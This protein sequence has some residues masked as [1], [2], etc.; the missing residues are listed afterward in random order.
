MNYERI[1]NELCYR[2]QNRKWSKF[3]YEKH[4]II[5]KSMGGS[6]YKQNIAILTPREHAVAHLLL[7]KFLT[8]KDKAK[9]I[10]ALKTMM[11]FRNKNRNQLTTREYDYLRKAYQIQCQT[12]EYSSWRSELTK[13][14]WTPERRHSVSEKTRQQWETGNKREI[15]GSDEYRSKKSEQTKDRWKNPEY[16]EWQSERAKLQWKDPDKRPDRSRKK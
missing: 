5:P 14:Q 8:G 12:P 11:N 4:H 3:T 6:N 15:F 16:V 7:V 2:S 1:Y 13:A 9:M 10:Y